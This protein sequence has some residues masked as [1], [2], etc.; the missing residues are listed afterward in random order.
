LS[1]D[2]AHCAALGATEHGSFVAAKRLSVD[3]PVAAA[4]PRSDCA[5][6]QGSV[7][8]TVGQALTAA[9]KCTLQGTQ[10]EAIYVTKQP[11]FSATTSLADLSPVCAAVP[12]ALNAS[13]Q[14]TE[15]LAVPDAL[16]R[17]D[18]HSNLLAPHRAARA[19]QLC[20]HVRSHHILLEHVLCRWR[21]DIG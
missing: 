17:A 13:I 9:L 3:A 6:V 10:R 14:R 12:T 4:V 18:Q 1:V 21:A 20:A 8:T 11:A 19:S 16:G 15:Q 7:A 2:A 5:A